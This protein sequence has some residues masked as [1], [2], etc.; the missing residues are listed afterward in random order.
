VEKISKEKLG[1]DKLKM[2]RKREWKRPNLKIAG[3]SRKTEFFA[4]DPDLTPPPV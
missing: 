4:F 1:S 3:V 2:A